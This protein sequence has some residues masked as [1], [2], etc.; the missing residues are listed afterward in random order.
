MPDRP[1]PHRHRP[2][3]RSSAF[4]AN[5]DVL[6]HRQA[7]PVGQDPFYRRTGICKNSKN[8][9]PDLGTCPTVALS[10]VDL[11]HVGPGRGRTAW[12]PVHKLLGGFS[13][14]VTA[15]QLHVRDDCPRTRDATSYAEFGAPVQAHGYTASSGIPATAIP[16]A[17][18]KRAVPRAQPCGKRLAMI[19]S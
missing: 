3:D 17:L 12:K 15:M 7:D 5:P 9:S 13:D 1:C 19:W 2:R 16:R 4:G 8:A 6:T 14:K 18:I 11:A 10:V